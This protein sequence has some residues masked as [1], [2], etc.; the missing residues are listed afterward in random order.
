MF[1]ILIFIQTV[2]I[3]IHSN[4][5]PSLKNVVQTNFFSFLITLLNLEALDIGGHL[6]DLFY[7]IETLARHEMLNSVH[8]PNTIKA[9]RAEL[10]FGRGLL[11]LGSILT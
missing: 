6:R 3:C 11:K 5:K 7:F 1:C 8:T 2:Y 9:L 4:I 10:G